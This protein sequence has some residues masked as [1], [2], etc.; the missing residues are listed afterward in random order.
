M[1]E[2]DPFYDNRNREAHR[3]L[4]LRGVC[5]KLKMTTGVEFD[6]QVDDPPQYPRKNFTAWLL[7]TG[8]LM[9]FDLDRVKTSYVLEGRASAKRGRP[10]GARQCAKD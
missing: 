6:V 7:G 5:A 2:H 10:K 3:V 9:A 1:T 4:C 8:V